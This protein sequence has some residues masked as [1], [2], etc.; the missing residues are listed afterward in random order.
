[1]WEPRE[2]EISQNSPEESLCRNQ[3]H[4]LKLQNCQSGLLRQEAKLQLSHSDSGVERDWEQDPS[5]PGVQSHGEEYIGQPT[6]LG[7]DGG[8][9]LCPAEERNT[10]HSQ[11]RQNTIERVVAVRQSILD[12][13]SNK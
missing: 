5:A 3:L 2:A 4:I 12:I 1:M 10:A 8:I 9:T 11:M 7:Q 13:L 6:K